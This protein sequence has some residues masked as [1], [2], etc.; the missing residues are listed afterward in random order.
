MA[1]CLNCHRN[2][3]YLATAADGYHRD[4]ATFHDRPA[5]APQDCNVCHN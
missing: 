5:N 2:N 1:E 4:P 3:D